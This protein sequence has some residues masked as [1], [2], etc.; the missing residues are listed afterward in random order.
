ML[1]LIGLIPLM[2]VYIWFRNYQIVVSAGENVLES[3]DDDIIIFV[4]IYNYS[5]VNIWKQLQPMILIHLMN[6]DFSFN[7]WT[8]VPCSE[9]YVLDSLTL[10]F[11][12]KVPPEWLWRHFI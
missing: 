5:N 1:L 12:I 4:I 3:S 10:A 9:E 2:E 7:M 11:V 6:K 8:R